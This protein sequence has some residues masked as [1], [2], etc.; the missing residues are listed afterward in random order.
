MIIVNSL[1]ILG[2]T[3]LKYSLYFQFHGKHQSKLLPGI[4]LNEIND[5]ILNNI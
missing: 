3:R 5:S 1:L 4:T 2:E